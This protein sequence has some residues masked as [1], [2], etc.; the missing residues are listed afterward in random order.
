MNKSKL[1][2]LVAALGMMAATGVYLVKLHPRLGA[3]GVKV[4]P[5]PLYDELG[6]LAAQQSV[7]LPDEVL[8]CKGTNTP[9]TQIELENL[10]KDTIFGR[11]LYQADDFA[12]ITS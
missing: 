6:N 12:A 5:G 11:K 4:G 7:L 10:P 3:P 8:G 2:V 1:L 9:V